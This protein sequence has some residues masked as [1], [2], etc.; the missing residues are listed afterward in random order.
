MTQAVKR[1]TVYAIREMGLYRIYAEPYATNPAS[2]RVLE[3]AGF[4]CEGTLRSNVFKDGKILDQFIYSYIGK[5]S[6]PPE[7]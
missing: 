3:K 2:A 6:A 4:T 5:T 1:L 7:V